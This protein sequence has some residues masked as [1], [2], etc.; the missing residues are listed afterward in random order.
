MASRKYW[1]IGQLT[2][3][4]L[5][6]FV[7]QPAAVFWVYG[8]PILMMLSLGM[9]F[10]ENVTE[11]IRVDLVR[12]QESGVGGRESEGQLTPSIEHALAGDSKFKVTSQPA[13]DW[14]KRLQAGKTD[15]VIESGA[16][17]TY[18]IWDE[19]HRAESRLAR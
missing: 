3:S 7:R 14:R 1:P 19:P 11:D 16:D 6:E 10:R 8:F 17:G 4:R 5:R 15:L 12:V 18:Q 2:L 13:E 9:A